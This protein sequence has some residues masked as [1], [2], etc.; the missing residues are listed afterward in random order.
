MALV[1]GL[2]EG[3]GKGHGDDRSN[4]RGLRKQPEVHG[5]ACRAAVPGTRRTHEP[6][7]A[8]G[9]KRR[10]KDKGR[11]SLD[12]RPW[13]VC[14][15]DAAC[16]CRAARERAHRG[17]VGG[18]DG[19]LGGKGGCAERRNGHEHCLYGRAQAAECGR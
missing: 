9:R 8:R 6:G 19:V 5:D 16:V 7:D 11:V 14:A 4:A 1:L 13:S 15:L 18:V 17:P 3:R 12:P 2:G 10:A